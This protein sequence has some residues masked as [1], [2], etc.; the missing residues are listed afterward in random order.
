M[1]KQIIIAAATLGTIV[2]GTTAVKA[3]DTTAT[4]RGA[5]ASATTSVNIKL[6]DMISIESKVAE[7]DLV[8][9]TRDDYN[10]AKTAEVADN[11]VIASSNNFKVEVKADGDAFTG[12]AGGKINTDVLEIAAK[13]GTGAYG[14]SITLTKGYQEL[15]DNVEKGLDKKIAIKYSISKENSKSFLG[16]KADNYTQNITYTVTTL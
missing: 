4:T 13:V 14:N 8:Y 9:A 5:T 16:L 15:I 7:V 3:Q 6:V 1:K 12:S 11:L 2:F 10:T